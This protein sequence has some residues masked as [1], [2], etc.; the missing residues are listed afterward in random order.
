MAREGRVGLGLGD[1]LVLVLAWIATCGLV[2][3]LGFYVGKGTQERR[4]GLEERIVR[5]PVTS[6]PPPEGQRPKNE[7]HFNFYEQLMPEHP[8]GERDAARPAAPVSVAEAPRPPAAHSPPPTPEPGV[9]A[10]TLLTPKVAE[11]DLDSVERLDANVVA[12]RGRL[13]HHRDALVR[14]EHRLLGEVHADADDDLIEE[15][16][17]PSHDVDV[18]VCAS[19]VCA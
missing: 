17:G 7:D 10:H 11:R 14:G 3:V 19:G 5:L 13:A 6:P 8:V 4:L 15:A 1:R 18:S 12:I 16:R 2:Y 9:T